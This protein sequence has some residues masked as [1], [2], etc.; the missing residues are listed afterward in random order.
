[1]ST[2][3]QLPIEENKAAVN[4]S[5]DNIVTLLSKII[6]LIFVQNFFHVTDVSKIVL[7]ANSCLTFSNPLSSILICHLR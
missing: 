1:M 6:S 3:E 2:E 7:F 5:E 4:Y